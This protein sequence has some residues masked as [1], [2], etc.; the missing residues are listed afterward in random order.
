MFRSFVYVFAGVLELCAMI[1]NE[2][3]LYVPI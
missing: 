2:G 3:L 1:L